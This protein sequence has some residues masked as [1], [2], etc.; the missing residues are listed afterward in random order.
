MDRRSFLKGSAAVVATTVAGT[1]SVIACPVADLPVPLMSTIGV[2]EFLEG[3]SQK[4]AYT[5]I[6]GNDEYMPLQ[7]T[8][9][10]P[11]YDCARA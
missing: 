4:M 2:E 5:I 7:F 3:L 1:T 8:G 10:I 6:Y 9:L 11:R